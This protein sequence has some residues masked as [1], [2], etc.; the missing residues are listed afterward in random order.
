MFLWINYGFFMYLFVKKKCRRKPYI[1]NVDYY[2]IHKFAE[3]SITKWEISVD[4]I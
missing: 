1:Y 3:N 4:R 2:P